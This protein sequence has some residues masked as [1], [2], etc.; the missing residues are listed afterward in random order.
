AIAP[1]VVARPVG[2]AAAL[3]HA[4]EPFVERDLRAADGKWFGDRDLLLWSFVR[5]APRLRWWRADDTL[6]RR[7]H[8]HD[9]AVVA[10]PEEMDTGA[11]RRCI[12]RRG[13]SHWRHQLEHVGS[14]RRG[15]ARRLL[16]LR[17]LILGCGVDRPVIV[18]RG[19]R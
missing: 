1:T 18:D 5:L 4:G 14:G 15:L 9:R 19:R 6:A 11:K 12:G 16:W 10:V 3:G 7:D 8:R 17:R 13:R 2:I